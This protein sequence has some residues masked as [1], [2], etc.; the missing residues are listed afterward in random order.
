MKINN[1]TQI[2]TDQT[3]M[4]TDRFNYLCKSVCNLCVSVLGWIIFTVII[5]L[6]SGCTSEYNLATKKE[7]LYMYSTDR[8]IRIGDAVANKII[9]HYEIVEDVDV[10]DRVQKI[11]DRI[12]AVCDRQDIVYFIKVIDDDI[13]NAISLPGGHIFVF[14]GLIDNVDNDDQLA[15]V[16]AH[17]VGH[18]TARHGI[19]RLQNS[20]G[21]LLLQIAAM[22]AGGGAAAGVN[23]ALTSL[24][25]EYS[26]RDEF[27]SD[28]LAVKYMTKAGFD[29]REMTVFLQKLKDEADKKTR[30]YSYWRTHPYI[31]KRKAV[32]NQEITGKLQFKDYLNLTENEF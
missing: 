2:F 26:Q 12:V 21:A 31:A 29:P 24:F 18:I 8:E 17:E 10:N 5:L 30:R 4:V 25:T 14:K 32:V 1:L 28:R 16:I 15:G 23:L 20:Y 19:K 11:L 13:M 6:I 22:E 7:E 27:E 9:N 3:R